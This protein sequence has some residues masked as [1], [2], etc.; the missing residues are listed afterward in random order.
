MHTEP[1][2]CTSIR[3]AEDRPVP[4]LLASLFLRLSKRGNAP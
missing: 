3:I 2:P 1:Q 4:D